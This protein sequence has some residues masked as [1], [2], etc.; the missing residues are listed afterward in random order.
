M[1]AGVGFGDSNALTV[2]SAA[3]TKA[4]AIAPRP[5]GAFSSQGREAEKVLAGQNSGAGATPNQ[6]AKNDLQYEEI[7]A[8]QV[9][10]IKVVV[11]QQQK[12]LGELLEHATVWELAG[13]ELKLFF[14]A[15]KK[16]F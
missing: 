7:T 4:E 6:H 8:E 16:S 11:Q 14:P 2:D 15:G 12:F 1:P 3:A 13:A 9:A 10:Q 5:N